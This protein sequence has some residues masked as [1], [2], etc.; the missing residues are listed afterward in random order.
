MSRLLACVFVGALILLPACGGGTGDNSATGTIVIGPLTMAL[1]FLPDVTGESHTV[2]LRNLSTAPATVYLTAFLPTGPTYPPGTVAVAVPP[3]GGVQV[4]LSVLMGAALRLGGW[5]EAETRDPTVLDPVT[6][7]PTPTAASG[8]VVAYMQRAEVGQETDSAL[9]AAFRN[10]LSYVSLNPHTLG[11]QVISRSFDPAPGGAVPVAITVDVSVY[12]AFGTLLGTTTEAIP[13]NGSQV[14]LPIVGTGRVDVVPTPQPAQPAPA[15][16]E[17]RIAVAGLEADPQVHIET[18][19]TD[20]VRPMPQRYVGFDLEFGVD[21]PG[22]VYDFGVEITNATGFGATLLLEAVYQANGNPILTQPRA[23]ILEA[24]RTKF[25]ATTT[26][27]SQG[28]VAGE[29]SPFDDIFGDVSLATGLDVFFVVF[30]VPTGVDISAR[31]FNSFKSFYRVLPGR[32]L[33]TDVM[34]CGVV[35][36]STTTTGVRN[37]VSLMNPRD[38]TVDVNISGFTPGGTEYMLSPVTVGPHARFD[39]SP[40][41]TIFRE[42]PSSTTE[43]PVP[44]M[45]FRLTSL[46]GVFFGARRDRRNVQDIILAMIPHAVRD[47]RAD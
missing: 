26:R 39:W 28:L 9:A 15:T 17:F 19:L 22:N 46:G 20:P 24:R 33:T 35:V 2:G 8:F 44:F 31:A 10:D 23:V 4:P 43:P 5:L 6:G 32:K 37:T 34:V 27:D 29:A 16:T 14:F 42:D 12:D 38:T 47:L 21:T 45:A 7:E 30:S 25:L 13:A 18:R 11:Y 36:P 41:G 40:D 1:P 3:R